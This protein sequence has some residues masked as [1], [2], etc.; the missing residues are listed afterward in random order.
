MDKERNGLKME[1][2]TLEDTRMTSGLKERSMNCKE[3]ALT[4]FSL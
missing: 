2:Y 4:H 1:V 3:I